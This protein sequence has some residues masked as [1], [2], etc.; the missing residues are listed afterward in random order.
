MCLCTL[1]LL[2]ASVQSPAIGA[3][4]DEPK[5]PENSSA[6]RLGAMANESKLTLEQALH[7]ALEKVS[8]TA[9]QIEL[10]KKDQ[11]IVWEVTVLTEKGNVDR[12]CVDGQDGSY[13]IPV[14]PSHGR[15]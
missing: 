8:G 7:R 12:V 1:A 14:S 2:V 6:R 4:A 11:K 10:Q 9:V 3:A 5:T 13:L 15:Q